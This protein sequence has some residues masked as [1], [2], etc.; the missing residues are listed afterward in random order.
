MSKQTAHRFARTHLQAGAV[1]DVKAAQLTEHGQAAEAC[2]GRS[3][4]G[5][6]APKAQVS[7]ITESCQLADQLVSHIGL[8]LQ[9][10]PATGILPT[11]AAAPGSMETV[12]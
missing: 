12:R 10:S 2:G 9:G 8:Q 11:S 7:Q 6:A 1:G 5:R 3:S 4:Q